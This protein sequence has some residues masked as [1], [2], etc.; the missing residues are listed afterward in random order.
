MGLVFFRVPF[1]VRHIEPSARIFSNYGRTV[2]PMKLNQRIRNHRGTWLVAILVILLVGGWWFEVPRLWLCNFADRALQRYRARD[3]L[4]WIERAERFYPN[5]IQLHLLEVRSNLQLN[6]NSL[7]LEWLERAKTR[8]ASHEV[9]EPY[10]LM[11]EAQRGNQ[12]AVESLLGSASASL[13]A[14]EALIRGYEHGNQW[15][16]ANLILDQMEKAGVSP[17]VVL[18]HRGRI[19]EISEDFEGAGRLY[20]EAYRKEPSSSRAAFRAGICFYNLRDFDRAAEMFSQSRF[21]PYK[22]VFAIELAGCLWEK[23]A[24]DQSARVITPTL[25]ITPSNLQTLYLQLDEFVDS[26]RAA[27][28]AARIEDALGHRES[29]VS[30]LRRSLS[31]NNREFDARGILIKNLRALGRISEADEVVMIQTQMVANRQ[32]CRQLRLEL[33]SNPRDISKFCELAEL[34]WYA[35]SDA[36]AMLAISEIL[37]MEP[38]CERALQLRGKIISNRAN[39]QLLHRPK[40]RL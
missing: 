16:M 27:L 22:D 8:G 18:Y 12:S 25:D 33:D 2:V 29:A 20:S 38:K 40:S 3:A 37:E 14:Y 10:R 6:M 15:S 1:F 7:A 11:A 4:L 19:L 28:V 34:Y 35:E 30:L 17:I 5:D 9:L 21:G 39:R 32:R 26:D 36:E 23:N 13:E 31:F 24:L